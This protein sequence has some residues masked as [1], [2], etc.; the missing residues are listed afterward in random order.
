MP[1]LLRKIVRVF[2]MNWSQLLQ[3]RSDVIVWTITEAITPLIAL[4]IW[5]TVAQNQSSALSPQDAITYYVLSMIVITGTNSWVSY[6]LTDDILTGTLVQSLIRPLSVFWHHAVDNIV[7]KA[8]RLILPVLAFTIVA[9]QWPHLFSPSIYDSSRIALAVLSVILGATIAF[10]ADALLATVAFWIEDSHQIIG[11]HYLLWT[12]SSGVLIPYTFL[13]DTLKTVLSF[14]PYRYIVSAPLEI[15]VTSSATLL[16]TQL[17]VIQLAW[18]A[19]LGTALYF[20][21]KQG[22]KRYAIPGQ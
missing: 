7:T 8:I 22:L 18:I 17:L 11:Y 10:L 21:W 6:F 20:A 9:W 1:K 12:I 16:P 13:P 14:L 5:F 4:A 15:L 3:Y 19:G 2:S